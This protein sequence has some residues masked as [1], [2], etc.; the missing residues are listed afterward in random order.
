MS[1]SEC[2]CIVLFEQF[3]FTEILNCD[4]KKLEAFDAIGS[5]CIF[6]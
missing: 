2:F 6:L 1:V 5:W 4:D 3:R